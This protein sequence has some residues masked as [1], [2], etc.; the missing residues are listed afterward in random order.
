[1]RHVPERF[2]I[3]RRLG[4][5]G[6]GIVYEAIDRERGERVALKALARMGAS[7]LYRFKREFRALADVTHDNLVRLHELIGSGDEW[8]FTMELVR[9]VDWLT[10][11]RGQG[12]AGGAASWPSLT[13]TASPDEGIDLDA[14]LEEQVERPPAPSPARAACAEARADVARVRSSLVQVAR[15][16]QAVHA[17][18]LVHRDV[19]PS[20]VLVTAEGRAVVLDFGIASRLSTSGSGQS[21]T[22]AEQL[23]G[24][25]RYMAPEQVGA[26]AVAPSADWYALGVMLFE[27]LA[28]RPPFTGT[29]IEV[30]A[31]KQRSEPPRLRDV[32]PWAP[33]DLADLAADLLCAAPERRPSGE[34]VVRRL[35]AAGDLAAAPPV[36]AAPVGHGG[37]GATRA[38]VEAR[39][40]RPRELEALAGALARVRE[41][42][43]G[44]ALVQGAA[45]ADR[46]ALVRAFLDGEAEDALVLEGR[47]HE[48]EQVPF[49]ALDG[50]IDALSRHLVRTPPGEAAALMPRGAAALARVFPVL[51]RVPA[52]RAAPRSAAEE[53]EERLRA[54]A[55]AALR[56]LL[57][58]ISDR[59]AVVVF[60]DDAHWGD[61]ES[62]TLLAEIMAPPD[63]AALLLIVAYRPE[64]AGASPLLSALRTSPAM[65]AVHT[66]EIDLTGTPA[67][68][69]PPCARGS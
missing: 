37:R 1:M 58:R 21:A 16:L 67:R 69:S 59:R 14:T 57:G 28:G 35:G 47:C 25:P 52:M 3:V 26:S 7:A 30:L 19:K 11:V 42:R 13:S 43:P 38:A 45:G 41:G 10:H 55:S 65:A 62:A 50:A 61:A 31:E 27:A 9:G 40:T 33:D 54:R 53:G 64:D 63:P 8:F 17:A 5:G 49:R 6:F 2:Q 36:P 39:A 34:E 46:G 15:A 12:S 29:S 44:L 22:D 24:T 51:A 56:D 18:R 68:R 66:V 32:A 23:I 48:R 4:A 60:I 20:N